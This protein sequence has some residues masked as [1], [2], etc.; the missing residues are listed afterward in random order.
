MPGER[1]VIG[2]IP[3][4]RVGLEL[5]GKHRVLVYVDV[6]N[7]WGENVNTIKNREFF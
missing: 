7:V 6:V 1:N 4:K 2:L 5:N 3:F